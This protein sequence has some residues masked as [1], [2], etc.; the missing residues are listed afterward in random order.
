MSYAFLHTGLRPSLK[1]ATVLLALACAAAAAGC[2]PGSSGGAVPEQGARAA[3]RDTTYRPEFAARTRGSRRAPVTVYELSDFQCPFCRR[4]ASETFPHLDSAYIRTGKVRWVFLNHP[5]RRA[6]KNADRAAQ[7]A[8]CAGEQRRFWP[9]HD[10]LFAG[11]AAWGPLEQPDSALHAVAAAVGANRAR[12]DACVAKDG[13]RASV[14]AD[15]AFARRL[16]IG[17]VPAFVVDGRMVA[18]GARP[19]EVFTAVL[20]SVLAAKGH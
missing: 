12:M 10:E 2:A 13:T 9:M 17:G 1:P 5:A 11:Q 14:V 4:F 6:H 3:Q 15:G 16:G 19:L 7:F 18:Q 20:D 8:L